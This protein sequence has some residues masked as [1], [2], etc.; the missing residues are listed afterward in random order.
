MTTATVDTAN[1]SKCKDCV[2][3]SHGWECATHFNIETN[4]PVELRMLIAD[5]AN[6]EPCSICNHCMSLHLY[7][8]T[9]GS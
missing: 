9:R 2:G 1:R 4:D 7:R 6:C 5:G 3:C 8:R